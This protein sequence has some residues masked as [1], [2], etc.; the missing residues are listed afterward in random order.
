MRGLIRLIIIL[1]AI[2]QNV[3]FLKIKKTVPKKILIAHNLLLGDTLLLAPL[4]KRIHEKYPDA[5]KFILAKP[6]FIPLFANTPY[7]FKALTFDPKNFLDIWKMFSLGPYDLSYIAGDNRYSWFARAIG[8]KWIVGISD[9]KPQ[10]KN[11]ML[12]EVRSF[13]LKPATW[14]DMM[15][16]LV[17]GRDPKPYKKDEWSRPNIKKTLSFIPSKSYVVCHLGASNPLKFW[18]AESW[19]VLIDK[20]KYM[21]FDIFISVGPGEEYLIR[22]ADPDSKCLHIAGT[23]SLLEMWYLI[24]HAKLLISVDTGIAHLAK[25][26]NTPIVTLFGPGS[27]VTHGAG[28]FWKLNPHMNITVSSFPCRDQKILFRRKVNWV[29]RCGRGIK[30]CRTPGACMEA[31]TPKQV[32]DTLLNSDLFSRLMKV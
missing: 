10:W 31:I 30:E 14:P 7:G 19:K 23:C 24:E 29:K 6:G 17:D 2:V 20:L 16:R 8:S 26:S 18:P 22:E 4:M 11:W 1:L 12:D 3:F 32:L 5:K 13:D 27:P 21:G 28:N 9:D 15:G 25:L